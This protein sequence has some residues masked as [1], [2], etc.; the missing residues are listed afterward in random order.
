MI[1]VKAT[2]SVDGYTVPEDQKKYPGERQ[3][4]RQFLR[5]VY[6]PFNW[7]PH[8]QTSGFKEIGQG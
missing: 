7:H 8:I 3:L 1:V 5:L 2:F 6:P 4:E